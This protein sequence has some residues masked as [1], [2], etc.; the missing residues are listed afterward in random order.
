ME[1]ANKRLRI[2]GAKLVLRNFQG[3]AGEYND[4]GDRNFGVLLDDGLAEDLER[5]GWSVKRFKPK[6]DDPT[7]YMQP[8]LKVR[9]G[10]FEPTAVLINSRGKVNLTRETIGQLDWT[11]IR[12]CDLIITG[13]PYKG[14]G[15][16]PDGISAYM[17]A[18]YVTVL[19]DEFAAKYSDIPDVGE[20]M[21]FD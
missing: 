5:D 7:G 14:R 10:K 9:Y 20:P 1:K 12:N 19:E 17:A 15:G 3:R 2:E 6:P 4:E 18:I 11:M 13:T 16:R 8:W 21:P